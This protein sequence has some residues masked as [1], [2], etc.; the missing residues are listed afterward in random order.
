MLLRTISNLSRVYCTLLS[1]PRWLHMTNIW[2]IKTVVPVLITYIN[3]E[4]HFC[5]CCVNNIHTIKKKYRLQKST[6]SDDEQKNW[7]HFVTNRLSFV[8][9]IVIYLQLVTS[10]LMRSDI[11]FKMSN[12]M[13]KHRRSLN[14]RIHLSKQ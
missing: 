7:S 1:K 12:V 6:K 2:Q 11:N 13:S 14:K 8:C 10:A 5:K 9:S 4:S 3:H